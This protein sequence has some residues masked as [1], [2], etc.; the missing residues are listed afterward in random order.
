MFTLLCSPEARASGLDGRNYLIDVVADDTEANILRVLFDDCGG[1]HDAE[2]E[3]QRSWSAYM[4]AYLD[5][6]L[7]ELLESSCLLHQE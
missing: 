2:S 7:T 6:G 1:P 5:E 3:L 4:L